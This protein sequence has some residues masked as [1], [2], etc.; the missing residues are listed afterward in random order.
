MNLGETGLT[1]EKQNATPVRNV[2]GFMVW[3]FSEVTECSL[4]EV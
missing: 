4:E 3:D 2:S 1:E